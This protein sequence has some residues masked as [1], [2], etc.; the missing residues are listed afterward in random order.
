[1]ITAEYLAEYALG[2]VKRPYW[3]GTCGHRACESLFDQKKK[4]YPNDDNYKGKTYVPDY[5][6][7][8]GEKVH[9]CCGLIKGAC[10]CTGIDKYFTGGSEYKSNGCG[11]WTVE[12]MYANC[13]ETGDISSLPEIKGLLVFT[14]TKGHVGVYVGDGYVV[15]ARGRKYGVQK[16]KLSSRSFKYW[17]KLKCIQ[18]EETDH[19][20]EFQSWLNKTYGEWLEVD[21]DYGDYTKRCAIR[22]MQRE[23]NKLGEHLVVDS[24]FGTLSQAALTRHMVKRGTKGNMAYIVQGCLYG[25]GYDCNGF[26]GSVGP[27]CD[28]AIRQYQADH[29]LEV[30]GK[31][32]GITF[33]Y[34]TKWSA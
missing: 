20:K 19:V 29:F 5:V 17:G 32:G 9:D 1:M 12:E 24:W 21:G 13:T 28:K 33:D 6:M 30:D 3:T 8:E 31:V 4:Q 25:N 15:E 34:L 7:D 10:W 27:G 16:N 14:K 18:Y 11:D 2:Q 22:A 23:L 26:D